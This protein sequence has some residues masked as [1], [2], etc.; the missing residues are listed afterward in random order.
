L[1]LIKSYNFI[2]A[3]EIILALVCIGIVSLIIFLWHLAT[4]ETTIIECI[5]NRIL[6]AGGCI[7]LFI[8]LINLCSWILYQLQL[9]LI[10]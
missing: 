7:V 2:D 5:I 3:M 6:L 4:S 8:L 1:E 10:M 9:I